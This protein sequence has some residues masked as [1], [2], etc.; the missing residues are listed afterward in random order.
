MCKC[1]NNST[2][3]WHWYRPLTTSLGAVIWGQFFDKMVAAYAGM[4]IWSLVASPN[5]QYLL[6]PV[7]DSQRHLSPDPS[8]C[9]W[10]SRRYSNSLAFWKTHRNSVC[11]I[12]PNTFFPTICSFVLNILDNW[13]PH[14]PKT[15]NSNIIEETQFC[16]NCASPSYN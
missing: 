15:V 10:Y 8:Q 14:P 3:N 12:V 1:G 11:C 5:C 2:C 6:L 9:V 16:L 13:L 7:S 4:L